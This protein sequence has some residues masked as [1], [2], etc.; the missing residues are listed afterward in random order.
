MAAC[1]EAV[2]RVKSE[3]PVWGKLIL[4]NASVQWKENN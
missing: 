3:V 1:C 2:E 4:E